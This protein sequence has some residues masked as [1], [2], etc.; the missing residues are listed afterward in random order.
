MCRNGDPPLG[1]SKM[2]AAA[3]AAAAAT[4]TTTTTTTTKM[5]MMKMMKMMVMK[6][7]MMMIYYYTQS[8]NTGIHKNA[9]SDNAIKDCHM[10][11]GPNYQNIFV[12]QLTH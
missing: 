9:D 11:E 10:Y 12:H 3:A 2:A 7:M 5:M 1:D 8:T 4:T 6:M